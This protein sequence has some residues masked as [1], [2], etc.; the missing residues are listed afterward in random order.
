MKMNKELCFNIENVNL[1]LEQ[2]LVDY[3]NVPIF[4]L[5]SGENQF[6]LALCTDIENLNYIIVK[7]PLIDVYNLLHGNISMRNAILNQK[8]YW[9]I[10]SGDEVALDVV[11]KKN[12]DTIENELLP[13]ADACFQVLT[14]QIES[15]VQKFDQEF[16]Y[17]QYILDNTKKTEVN[18]L[19][20]SL[21]FDII[22]ENVTQ[23]TELLDYKIKI[24]LS[25][26]VPIYDE[27]MN[28]IK[29]SEVIIKKSEQTEQSKTNNSFKLAEPN[30]NSIAVAA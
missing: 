14:K 25:S 9:N 16:F 4:F 18:E 13:E 23:F 7:L 1:Y 17:T 28:L 26:E 10:I 21:S 20:T 12:I 11:I 24:P 15:F 19:L 5:C 2:V 6:Y 22:L 27:K 29:T 3:M 30:I 8:E